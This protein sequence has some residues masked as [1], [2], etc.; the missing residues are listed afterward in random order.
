MTSRQRLAFELQKKATSLREA[1][2]GL[3]V[4]AEQVLERRSTEDIDEE[5]QEKA[6]AGKA[7]RTAAVNRAM[8]QAVANK[9]VEELRAHLPSDDVTGKPGPFVAE[10][11]AS[12]DAEYAQVDKLRA[13]LAPSN[14]V[15]P[16]DMRVV[17]KT[18]A[19]EERMDAQVP[20]KVACYVCG[21]A[22]RQGRGSFNYVDATPPYFE[23][24]RSCSN[25][26][27]S[28]WKQRA[29]QDVQTKAPQADAI[30]SKG[31]T[32]PREYETLYTAGRASQIDVTGVSDHPAVRQAV[33]DWEHG[34]LSGERLQLIAD[35]VA[36]SPECA[37]WQSG[38]GTWIC[39]THRT[40]LNHGVCPV[41]NR[42]LIEPVDVA[43]VENDPAVQLAVR[44]R[45]NGDCSAGW[46]KR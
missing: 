14:K 20:P 38:D 21:K 43:G 16:Y 3:S 30:P 40:Q 45:K 1:A 19:W 27:F 42:R 29:L 9:Q 33:R 32:E 6:D 8:D 12:L 41:T 28:S 2:N 46:V 34:R 31:K 25:S 15:D 18:D 26:L 36:K 4:L 39:A 13:R 17:D 7:R 23:H 37:A 35:G 44:D 22:I 24:W 11:K 5:L 10:L